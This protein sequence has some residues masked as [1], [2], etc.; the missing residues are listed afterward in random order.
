MYC[1]AK[2]IEMEN[3]IFKKVCIKNRACYYNDYIKFD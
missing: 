1:R 2:N 3:N